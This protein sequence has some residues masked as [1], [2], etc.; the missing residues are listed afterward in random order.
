M[1]RWWR[2]GSRLAVSLALSPLVAGLLDVVY[3]ARVGGDYMHARLVLPG[4]F[5]IC[6]SLFVGRRHLKST[7]TLLVGIIGI[8]SIVCVG[9]LRHGGPENAAQYIADERSIWVAASG[10]QHPIMPIDFRNTLPYKAGVYYR[11]LAQHVRAGHQEIF[12]QTIL[13]NPYKGERLPA[14][15]SLPFSLATNLP[16]IGIAG[17]ES[18]PKV[19]IFDQTSLA[20]PIGSHTEGLAGRDGKNIGASWMVARFALPSESKTTESTSVSAARSALACAPLRSYLHAIS[21]PLTASTAASEFLHAFSYSKMRFS[22]APREA[23]QQLCGNA[24][25]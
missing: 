17:I 22:A 23:E 14:S 8:W 3:V 10:M 24:K 20:N 1:M 19:Y 6:C 18:G 5:A 12:V 16:G 4:F 13:F 9:W 11:D 7:F 21:T 15:S 25:D 2:A